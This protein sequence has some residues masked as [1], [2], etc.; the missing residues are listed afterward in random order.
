MTS[1]VLIAGARPLGD[2][3]CAARVLRREARKVVDVACIHET[4]VGVWPKDLSFVEGL[5]AGLNG[6]EDTTL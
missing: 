2:G 1:K 4:S 6:T 3:C 5:V